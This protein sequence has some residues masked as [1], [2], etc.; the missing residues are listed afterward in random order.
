[1]ARFAELLRDSKW[2]RQGS[3][4]EVLRALE[5]LPNDYKAK[6]QCQEVYEL[7]TRAQQLSVSKWKTEMGR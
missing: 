2:V 6:P 5:R 7:V 3:Y 4:A 1:V